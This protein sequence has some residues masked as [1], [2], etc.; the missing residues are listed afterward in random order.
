MTKL[1]LARILVV[2]DDEVMRTFVVNTL[3]RMGIQTI[4]TATDGVQALRVMITFRPDLVLT[5][6]HMQPMDGLEFVQ[7]LRGHSNPLVKNMKIIFMSADA[8]TATLESAMPLGT[9][10]YIV[11]PPRLENLQTKLELA[12]K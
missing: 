3:R 12:L 7:Q 2:D 1:A 8:S 6:I 4:E 10:G 11:K 5:D 9:F